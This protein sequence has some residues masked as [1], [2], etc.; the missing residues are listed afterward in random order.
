MFARKLKRVDLHV[1]FQC[2]ECEESFRASDTAKHCPYCFST[3]RSNLVILH[4]EEDEERAQYLEL[5]D[6]AAGD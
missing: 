4:L 3:D 6:F 1:I 2:Q 5:V